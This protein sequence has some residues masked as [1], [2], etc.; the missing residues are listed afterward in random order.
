MIE[1]PSGTINELVYLHTTYYNS[2]YS[3]YPTLTDLFALLKEI[4]EANETTKYIHITPFYVN[5]K[6]DFQEEFDIAHFYVECQATATTEEQQNYA[7][8]QMFWLE[9]DSEY[10]LLEQ[11]ITLEDMQ[12]SHF[13]VEFSDVSGFQQGIKSYMDF[14]MDRG[15]PQMMKWLYRFYKLD[16]ETMPYGY[17]CFEVHSD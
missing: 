16:E 8:E 12:R 13:L 10:K 3:H 11:Y 1:K 5:E 14:L 2:R 9:P 17:F 4:I 15:I 7:H 6:L